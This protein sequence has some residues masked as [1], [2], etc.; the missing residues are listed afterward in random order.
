MKSRYILSG[1][2]EGRRKDIG[3]VTAERLKEQERSGEVI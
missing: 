1:K 2:S 3:R